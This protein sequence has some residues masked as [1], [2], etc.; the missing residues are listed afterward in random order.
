[1]TPLTVL[2]L[3]VLGAV[4]F[5]GGMTSLAA[6][7]RLNRDTWRES[8]R[9]RAQIAAEG[10]E[11][12]RRAVLAQLADDRKPRCQHHTGGIPCAL[13]AEHADTRHLVDPDDVVAA[14]YVPTPF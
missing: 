3:F 13:P 4:A 1:M 9:W 12:A 6:A 7:V 14:G 10:R 2:V 8:D 5:L 11:R